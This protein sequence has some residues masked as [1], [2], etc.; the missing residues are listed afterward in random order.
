[1][2]ISSFGPVA[3]HCKAGPR[4]VRA[5]RHAEGSCHGAAELAPTAPIP[6]ECQPIGGARGWNALRSACTSTNAASAAARYRNSTAWGAGRQGGVASTSVLASAI[7]AQIT[8][9]SSG[10]PG[11]TSR[12]ACSRA[13]PEA[14]ACE[15][16]SSACK[17]ATAKTPDRLAS[18]AA[19]AACAPP[20][21]C[22][23]DSR[24]WIASA[25]S[26]RRDPNLTF[27]RNHFMPAIASS[28]TFDTFRSLVLLQYNIS[29]TTPREVFILRPNSGSGCDRCRSI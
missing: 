1:M 16:R 13:A 14:I 6:G 18:I 26:A 21:K 24:N 12:E 3:D 15:T 22:P 11:G 10:W 28:G 2:L 5:L 25:K 17:C 8:Q 19:D 20:W 29:A 7:M 23:N 27:D 4:P 9:S